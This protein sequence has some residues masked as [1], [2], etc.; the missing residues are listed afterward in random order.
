[1]VNVPR[2]SDAQRVVLNRLRADVM[3]VMQSL[4]MLDASSEQTLECVPLGL[5]RSNAT[6]RHGVTR[7]RRESGALQ[8]LTVDLHPRLLDEAWSSYAAFVLYHEFLHALGW[9]A[10]NR[11]FRSLESAW[12]DSEASTLGPSFTHAM[13]AEQA[14]WWWV[15]NTCGGRYPRK[16][17]SKGRYQ[18][19]LCLTPLHDVK[20][21]G[22]S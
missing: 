11:D 4:G 20:A 10:H 13:R 8:L 19:R 18:C 7:W 12:P 5:L 21:N 22:G 14:V 2:P 6:Q 3:A 1:M 9:R 17:P 15:C 16:K